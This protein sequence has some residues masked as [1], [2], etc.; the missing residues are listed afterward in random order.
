MRPGDFF[1]LRSTKTTRGHL[2]K[3]FKSQCTS[4]IKSSFL[5]NGLLIFGIICLV[6]LLIFPHSLHSSAQL[7]VL[8]SVIFLISSS[9]S[10]IWFYKCILCFILVF[11]C[12]PL[13]VVSAEFLAMSACY[14]LLHLLYRYFVFSA[15]K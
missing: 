6:T 1:M 11:H 5:L 8:I 3:L 13:A 7:S 14:M 2:Y 12:S 10:A 15:N 9:C 4:A